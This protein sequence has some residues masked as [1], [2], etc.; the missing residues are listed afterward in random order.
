MLIDEYGLPED[1]N[2]DLEKC[3][4]HGPLGNMPRRRK[5]LQETSNKKQKISNIGARVNTRFMVLVR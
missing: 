1:E 3:N 5:I 2:S 4:A